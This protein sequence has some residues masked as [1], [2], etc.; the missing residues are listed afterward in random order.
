MKIKYIAQNDDR[1]YNDL[2]EFLEDKDIKLEEHK[3]SSYPLLP[4]FIS[5]YMQNNDIK[6][7]KEFLISSS[8]FKN[9]DIFFHKGKIDKT[10]IEAIKSAKQVIVSSYT[11]KSLIEAKIGRLDHINI[12]YPY[13]E[14][15]KKDKDSLKEDIF[16]EINISNPD[17]HIIL[18]H[19]KNFKSNGIKEFLN[20]ISS[21]SQRNFVAFIV[22][23][24]E[25]INKSKFLIES[26]QQQKQHVYLIDI[27][28][29]PFSLDDIYAVSDI[30]IL[31][32]QRTL[33]S[34][35]ILKA[36][37]YKSVVMIPSSNGASEIVDAFS[38]MNSADDSTVAFKLDALLQRKKDLKLVQKTNKKIAKEFKKKKYLKSLV[39]FIETMK[40]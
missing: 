10:N 30:Y 35:N 22:G 37:A 1:F 17:E 3:L 21:L 40:H 19:A 4:K 14:V 13:I 15:E 9:L 38:I 32:T 25:Q 26:F 16:K 12:L 5:K 34:T 7:K 24:S 33:F 29:R 18:F 31:P 39:K 27:D 8:P 6:K 28:T 36:M 23:D 20:I 2:K 11:Q